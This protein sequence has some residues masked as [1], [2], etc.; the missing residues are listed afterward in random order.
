V[1]AYETL[2]NCEPKAC[3]ETHHGKKFTEISS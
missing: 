3:C 2:F 1:T